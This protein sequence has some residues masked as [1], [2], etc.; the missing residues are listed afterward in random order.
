MLVSL[1][2]FN[3][4]IKFCKRDFI[5]TVFMKR[6]IEEWTPEWATSFGEEVNTRSMQDE[7]VDKRRAGLV[8]TLLGHNKK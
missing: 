6:R 8:M 3:A 7:D 4:L 5:V 1:W 2:V